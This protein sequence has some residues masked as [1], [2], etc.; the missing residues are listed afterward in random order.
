MAW[1]PVENVAGS[2]LALYALTHVAEQGCCTLVPFA[3]HM[4]A[5]VAKIADTKRDRPQ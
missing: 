1:P 5:H 3:P 2:M 4:V